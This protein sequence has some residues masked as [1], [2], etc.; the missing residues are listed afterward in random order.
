[1]PIYEYVCRTCGHAFE[2]LIRTGDKA[3]CPSCQNQDLERQLSMISVSSESIRAANVVKAKKA[4]R[5]VQKERQ[6]AQRDAIR[7]H[8]AEHD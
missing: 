4:V 8:L 6:G 2:Q 3:T 5:H 1:M 7:N